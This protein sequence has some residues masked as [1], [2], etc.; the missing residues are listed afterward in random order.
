MSY[1]VLLIKQMIEG[2]KCFLIDVETTF[3]HGEL[4]E[5]IF[6]ECPKGLEHENDE[7]L[8]LKKSLYRLVQVA[9]QFHKKWSEILKKIGFEVN[10]ADLCLFLKENKIFIG[11]YVDDNY[12]IG[13]NNDV[14][15]FIEDVKNEGLKLTVEEGLNDYLS[16]NIVFDETGKKAW[17]GQP[18]LLKKLEKDFGEEVKKMRVYKT[19]G[20]PMIGIKR[21]HTE[22]EL[23]DS[24][25]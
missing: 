25:M 18:H 9:R 14:R 5:M 3:L 20:T 1:Q 12:V 15:K 16:C 17:I 2:L 6:M 4:D 23:L 7:I 13:S 22:E 21:P 11:T 10:E 24:V 8:L 19:P